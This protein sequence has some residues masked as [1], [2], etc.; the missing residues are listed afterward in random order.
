[1]RLPSDQADAEMEIFTDQESTRFIVA[2]DP[3][4]QP[5][6]RFLLATGCRFGEAAAVQAGDL[7]PDAR[8][9]R[10]RRAWKKGE[11]GVY[12]GAPKTR[13]STRAVVLP[14]A[15]ASELADLASGLTHD[16]LLFTSRQGRRIQ[17]QHYRERFWLPALERAG[18][19]KHL[20]PHSL[21]HTGASW[22]LARN[23]SPIVVQ[24]RLG[25]ESLSTT[26]K[27]YAH[28]LTDEQLGA[29]AAMDAATSRPA[30]LVPAT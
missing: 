18:I 12:L 27:V 25:H 19:T 13:R 11:T 22:L 1:M 4:Y 26:S 21:R 24:H 20:T 16:E 9:V 10:I 23:V 2:V 30:E 3:H 14:P 7:D 28:L 6:T 8:T 5:L 17:A 15:L 29:A